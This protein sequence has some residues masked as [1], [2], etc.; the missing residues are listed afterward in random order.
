MVVRDELLEAVEEIVEV[1][2]RWRRAY[3]GWQRAA[4]R[5]DRLAERM[6]RR[7]TNATGGLSVARWE[8]LC[9]RRSFRTVED[10]KAKARAIRARSAVEAAAAERDRVIADADAKVRSARI[11]LAHASKAVARYGSTG[12]DMIGQSALTLR[13]FSRLPPTT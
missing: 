8:V 9:R 12:L 13:R 7:V 4:K 5:R 1:A 11:D 6:E 10:A 3:E 2:G